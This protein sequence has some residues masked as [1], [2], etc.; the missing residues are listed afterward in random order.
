MQTHIYLLC[1][2][3]VT[4]WRLSLPSW[5]GDEHVGWVSSCVCVPW[6]CGW[7]HTAPTLPPDG[8]GCSHRWTHTMD[9]PLHPTCPKALCSPKLHCNYYWPNSSLPP[10]EFCMTDMD[11][12]APG[13]DFSLLS[14]LL[15]TVHRVS[16]VCS[17]CFAT[18]AYLMAFLP[19]I[20]LLIS[21]L[22]FDSLSIL[23][24]PQGM[25]YLTYGSLCVAFPLYHH[26]NPHIKPTSP[27]SVCP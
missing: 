5:G 6:S 27:V 24:P 15:S 8:T 25:V 26:D 19:P 13:K 21:Y 16:M 2:G 12:Y 1:P 11:H 18:L 22:F 14:L 4:P 7:G 10:L 23:N 9:G 20:A 17:Y 3:L